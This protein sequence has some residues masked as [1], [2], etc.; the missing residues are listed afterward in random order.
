VGDLRPRGN[1]EQR[2]LWT[3]RHPWLAGFYFAA[4]FTPAFVVMSA[5]VFGWGVDVIAAI[6]MFPV[7]WLSFGVVVKWRP[8]RR[9]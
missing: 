6:L 4:V 8:V 7:A 2:A 3:D 1:T 9:L 5:L